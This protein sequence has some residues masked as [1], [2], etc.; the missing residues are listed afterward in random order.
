MAATYRI[1]SRTKEGV[2]LATLPQKDLQGEI[3]LSGSYGARFSIPLNYVNSMGWTTTDIE[4]GRTEVQIFRNDI[5]IYTG[6]LWNVDVSANDNSFKCTSEDLSSYFD[7]RQLEVATTYA[8][9]LGDISWNMIRDTQ[10][11]ANGALGITRGTPVSANGPAGTLA[12][13]NAEYI[14]DILDT[15][16]GGTTGFDWMITPQRVYNQYYPRIN[17]RANVSLD[18]PGN[19]MKYGINYQGKYARNKVRTI[20]ANSTISN[21]AVDATSLAKFGV[22]HYS[23]SQTNIS[24]VALLDAYN[25]QMLLQR[26]NPL[27]VPNLTVISTLVNPFEGDI[28]LGQVTKVNIQDGYVTMVQDMRFVGFQ[29][30]PGNQGQESFVFYL[31]DLREV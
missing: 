6:P 14:S 28:S 12:F 5:L 29:Y 23:E 20:G 26:K 9:T 8:G 10:D 7:V 17:S 25:G 18:Y 21:F 16:S 4:A 22:R 24:S 31:N 15:L 1:E 3:M 13:K 19:I 27:I 11:L 30:T 2:Y